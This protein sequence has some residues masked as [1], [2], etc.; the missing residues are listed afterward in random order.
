MNVGTRIGVGFGAL[1]LLAVVGGGYSALTMRTASQRADVLDNQNLEEVK[2]VASLANEFSS[3]VLS[4][5][6]YGYSGDVKDLEQSRS[7]LQR[8]DKTLEEARQLVQKFPGLGELNETV[9]ETTPL[10]KEF[11]ELIKQTEEDIGAIDA[12]R[13]TMNQTASLAS[14]LTDQ[15][16]DIQVKKLS[17]EIEEGK[18]AEELKIREGKLEHIADARILL[19]EARVRVFRGQVLRDPA[20]IESSQDTFTSTLRVMQELVESMSDESDIAAANEAIKAIEEYRGAVEI[21]Q[22]GFTDLLATAR[23][24][25]EVGGKADESYQQAFGAGVKSIES[26]S[27]ESTAKLHSTAIFASVGVGASLVLGSVI[28]FF[29]TRSIRGQLTNAAD[30]LGLGASQVASA[31]GQ[32]SSSSQSLAQGASEQAASLEETTAALEEMSSMTRKNAETAREAATLATQ[33]RGA[34]DKGAQAMVRM[35]SAINEIQKSATETA[36]IIKVIDEIAFQTNLLALNAAVEA[37]RAGEAG[38][39]F[40][41]VAEEVRNLAMRSAEA[42]KNTSSLIEGSVQ[43]SRNGV[44]VAQEVAN[45]LNE[46]NHAATKVD[47]MVGEIA[48]ASREQSQGIEQVNTAIVQMDKVT[49]SNAAAAEESAAASEELSSQARELNGIVNE[50]QSLVGGADATGSSSVDRV[51]QSRTSASRG[52]VNAGNSPAQSFREPTLSRSGGG[53]AIPF[54]DDEATAFNEFKS[55]A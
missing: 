46:I 45:V 26:A 53:H 54:S 29:L 4:S 40:A 25:T 32:V 16:Y 1:V 41:V 2:L 9:T 43:S 10:L 38:K 44:S 30:K 17:N 36:K 19:N 21:V 6:N 50:L 48:A 12:A 49:Q 55:A 23:K 52:R 8:A 39:G 24:R 13:K 22:K 31:S 42:A 18:S 5:H 15:I 51:P 28:G 20:Q 27:E 34:A 14:E 11:N 37:A 35:E 33:T 7:H 47:S 3:S